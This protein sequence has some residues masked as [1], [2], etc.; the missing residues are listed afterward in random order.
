MVWEI[1]DGYNLVKLEVLGDEKI[2]FFNVVEIL[3]VCEILIK[4]G[5]EVMVYIL[6]DL[7]IVK[8]LE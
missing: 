6:D 7:I 1:L 2:L 8:E 4:E 5:F 3:F